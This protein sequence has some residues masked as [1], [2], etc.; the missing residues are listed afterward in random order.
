MQIMARQESNKGTLAIS[1]MIQERLRHRTQA[2][3][4][5]VTL[6]AHPDE[7]I[8]CAFVEARLGAGESLPVI[9]HLIGCGVCRRATAQLM[10]LEHQLDE[11]EDLALE[12]SS[13]RL[14]A[15]LNDLASR[16]TSHD[17]NVVFAYQDPQTNEGK[18]ASESSDS[19]TEDDELPQSKNEPQSDRE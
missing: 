19:R 18:D 11:N 13:G 7:D 3:S 16:L 8:I 9:S 14:R 6:N 10:R 15:F 17:E 4:S 1:Y 12:E 2:E 5:D